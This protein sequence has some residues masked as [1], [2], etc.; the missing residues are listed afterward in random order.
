MPWTVSR[1]ERRAA[2]ARS[3]A[4]S[5]SASR[6]W[7]PAPV[8][9]SSASARTR[10][11]PR[12][13][14]RATSSRWAPSC[15]S[16]SMRVRSASKASTRV[17]RPAV[18][19]PTSAVR[20][21]TRSSCEESVSAWVR[22]ARR[23]P[24]AW[25][26]PQAAARQAAPSGTS[27]HPCP[28]ELMS[29]DQAS[30]WSLSG[31]WADSREG[32]AQRMADRAPP[33]AATSR[34]GAHRAPPTSMSGRSRVQQPGCRARVISHDQGPCPGGLEE[35]ARAPASRAQARSSSA[36]SGAVTGR[37]GRRKI[38]SIS[39]GMKVSACASSTRMTTPR[40]RRCGPV[41][42]EACGMDVTADGVASHGCQ[43][44]GDRWCRHHSSVV[45]VTA[46]RWPSPPCKS[47]AGARDPA[48]AAAV[49]W[50]T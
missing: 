11:M 16:R 12:A 39:S 13:M 14:V 19:C 6:A 22:R 25:S 32:R 24:R 4:V 33:P 2:S 41:V 42:G 8:S 34:L 31:A 50:R 9:P 21:A 37:S 47:G 49:T 45:F 1:R 23:R 38:P 26:R 36:A 7:R 5:R 46:G 17:A 20:V 48:G 40:G 29:A 10:A 27:H 28:A 44:P 43:A 30:R 18:R 35:G 3:W 15:R